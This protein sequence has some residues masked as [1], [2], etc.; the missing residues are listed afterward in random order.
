MKLLNLFGLLLLPILLL[1]QNSPLN[2]NFSENY[3]FFNPAYLNSD[4]QAWN[5]IAINGFY[6]MQQFGN[7]AADVPKTYGVNGAKLN[8]GKFINSLGGHIMMDKAGDFKTLSAGVRL[9]IRLFKNPNVLMAARV[10][11]IE[12]RIS[13]SSNHLKD[14]I[15]QQNTNK[16]YRTK[17]NLGLFLYT[18]DGFHFG[19]SVYTF[20]KEEDWNATFLIGKKVKNVEIKG[21]WGYYKYAPD[22]ISLNFESCLPVDNAGNFE[23]LLGANGAVD[24]N[25][26]KYYGLKIGIKSMQFGGSISDVWR[27]SLGYNFSNYRSNLSFLNYETYQLKFSILL[28]ANKHTN[29]NLFQ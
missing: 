8:F 26:Q 3:I 14:E 24:F 15:A 29:F 28:S 20:I 16:T 10:E 5:G 6:N 2:T 9:S 23:L 27:A 22:I 25:S 11:G 4:E 18:N 12:N 17:A 7:N 21:G 19:T 1:G 13:F